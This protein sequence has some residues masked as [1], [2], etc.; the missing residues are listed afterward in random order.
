MLRRTLPLLAGT[1]LV[2]SACSD[3][4]EDG[5]PVGPSVSPQTAAAPSSQEPWIVPGRVLV[6]FRP[7]A[8]AD[9]LAAAAGGSVDRVMALGIRV[10]SVPAGAEARVAA[11]LAR[12]PNVVFAEPDLIVPLG[13]PAV[14]PV[15]DAFIGYKWDLDNDGT[16][17]DSNGT[18]IGTTGQVDADMD[19]REAVEQY[20]SAS[21]SA[22]IGIMDSGI[23]QDHEEFVGRIAA[24]YDFFDGDADPE[25]D[26]G[27]GTHVA[28]IAAGA[29]DNGLGMAGVAYT[30]NVTLAIAKVCGPTGRGRFKSYGCPS[31]AIADGI[32]WAV[33]N[34]AD[35]LNLSLGGGGGSSAQQS[36]LQYARAN[37]VLA[38]CASGNDNGAVSY[39]G[40]FPEC[41]AVGATDWN[42]TRASY[43][44]FGPEVELSAPGGDDEDSGGLS[45]IASAYNGASNDYALLAGTSMA[46]PQAAGLA[47]L[48]KAFGATGWSDILA[49]MKA[50]AD[51]LGPSGRDN[52]FGEGRINVLAAVAAVAGGEPPPPPGNEAPQASFTHDCTDLSCAFTDTSTDDVGVTSWSWDF[53]DGATSTSRNPSHTYAAEGTYTV[54]LT[55]GDG[56]FT[57]QTS[58]AV[59]VS[60]PSPGGITLSASGYKQRG[61]QKADLAW[62]GATSTNVDIFRDGSLIATTA[63][64][65]AYTDPIDQRGGGSY[66]YR[67]CEAGGGPCS[68]DVT[69]TF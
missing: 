24:G 39:P 42:D 58:Q 45:Y 34:G 15:N 25:D 52:S 33:D 14:M 61:L 49:T 26:N 19:W 21:G 5:T 69:V 9:E 30:G 60:E 2:V 20:P 43:S 54:T 68:P 35:V 27:H 4:P 37:D 23:R 53:G 12:N 16:I 7:G 28:G 3:R 8:P 67:V 59:T 57:D 48:L 62:S 18:P 17:Y 56:E 46:S 10:L 65:G 63:N 40:A 64:D 31:S 55:V 11:A 6:Q 47:A 13:D 32:V 41:V 50:T 66:T 29:T 44:N 22:R 38:F 1:L 36:A 51:D